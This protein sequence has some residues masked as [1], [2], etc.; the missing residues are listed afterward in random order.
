MQQLGRY[1]AIVPLLGILGCGPSIQAQCQAISEITQDAMTQ[2][3]EAYS[4]NIGTSGYQASTETAIAAALKESA[5]AMDAL[6]IHDKQLQVVQADLVSAYDKAAAAHTE[7]AQLIPAR[8]NPSAQRRQ[9]IDDI[10]AQAEAD[11]PPAIQA[12]SLRCV[13]Y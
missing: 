9:Q 10:R 7:M 13:G 8:G 3:A 11:I 1:G 6:E 4:A 12:L 2:F 5:Q